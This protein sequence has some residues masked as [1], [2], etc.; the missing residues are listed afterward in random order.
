MSNLQSMVWGGL[1]RTREPRQGCMGGGCGEQVSFNPVLFQAWVFLLLLYFILFL[2]VGSRL[3]YF[4]SKNYVLA[5]QVT[6]L[7]FS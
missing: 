5:W 3:F 1:G 6:F 2:V 4:S 7:P